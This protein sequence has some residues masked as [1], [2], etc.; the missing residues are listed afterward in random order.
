MNARASQ[1]SDEGPP[2]YSLRPVRLED[3]EQIARHRYLMFAEAGFEEERLALITPKFKSWLTD[4]LTT[5]SYRGWFALCRSTGDVAAG[6]GTMVLDWPPHPHHEDAGRG[7]LLNIYTEPDHRRKGLARWLVT[8]ALE[9]AGD[10]R[11]ALV[12]L[13]ATS[14]GE[15]LYAQLGF[16]PSNEMQWFAQPRW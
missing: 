3:A 11:L 10:Q 7:Y 2:G 4:K 16:E 13:H 1:G 14:M 15:P 5:G 9:A 6:L 12:T 8:T